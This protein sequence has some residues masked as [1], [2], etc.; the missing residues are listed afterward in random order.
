M[1]VAK[2]M[3][4]KFNL[5]DEVKAAIIKETIVV[6]QDSYILTPRAIA[7]LDAIYGSTWDNSVETINQQIRGD[8]PEPELE[9][10]YEDGSK[11]TMKGEYTFGTFQKVCPPHDQKFID[12]VPYGW[13]IEQ[14]RANYPSLYIFHAGDLKKLIRMGEGYAKWLKDLEFIK[15][16]QFEQI[17][18]P[19]SFE[20]TVHLYMDKDLLTIQEACERGIVVN[21]SHPYHWRYSKKLKGI[22]FLDYK[23][24]A[25]WDPKE[26]KGVCFVG[27]SD[28]SVAAKIAALATDYEFLFDGSLTNGTEISRFDILKG[29]PGH[30]PTGKTLFAISTGLLTSDIHAEYSRTFEEQPKEVTPTVRTNGRQK[31]IDNGKCQWPAAKQRKGHR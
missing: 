17:E 3:I 29:R 1:K 26:V 11:L 8:H 12:S 10:G 24:T 7:I 15:N 16:S 21:G 22:L 5:P 6:D 27:G 13:E 23:Q 25:P 19:Y 30:L 4:N 9:I 28:K 2:D 18:N 14:I 31:I 20:Y